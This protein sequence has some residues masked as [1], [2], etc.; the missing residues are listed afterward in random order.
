MTQFIRIIGK[1]YL[2]FG[3]FL[4]ANLWA[5]PIALVKSISGKAFVFHEGNVEELTIGMS[6]EDFSSIS[7]EVG[8]QVSISDYYDRT[9]HLSGSGNLTFMKNLLEL[10]TG[11]LWV[12]APSQNQNVV[13]K[14]SNAQIIFS[15]A[16]GVISYDPTSE[17][18]QVLTIGGHFDIA[19]IER[20]NLTE[21]VQ[22]GMFSFIDKSYEDG[23]PRRSTPVG[24]K[25][26]LKIVSLFSGIEPIEKNILIGGNLISYENSISKP[27]GRFLASTTLPEKNTVSNTDKTLITNE[28]NKL[29]IKPAKSKLP[30]Y[31][32]R[33]NIYKPILNDKQAKQEV[34]TKVNRLPSSIS[35]PIVENNNEGFAEDLVKEYKNQQKHQKDLKNLIQELDS[36]KGNFNTNY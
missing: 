1:L 9:F 15:K 21:R 30:T 22:S 35:Q 13:L 34:N 10:K 11:Y 2:L 12:Q 16:E 20:T 19:N 27:T 28:F 4:S 24:K 6:I 7:T 29:K 17:K 14:T 31:P 33:I 23:S 18:T 32:V 8:G 3:I 36:Y 25:S 26:Y 5:K